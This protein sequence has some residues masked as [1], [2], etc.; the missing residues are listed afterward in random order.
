MPKTNIEIAQQTQ[1]KFHFYITALVFTLLGLSIQTA[2]F[3]NSDVANLL[4]LSGWAAL[5]ISGLTA[6]YRLE[7]IPNL[8]ESAAGLNKLKSQKS[9][10]LQSKKAGQE[11]VF[12]IEENKSEKID[13]YVTDLDKQIARLGDHLM[14][15]QKSIERRYILHKWTFIV[16]LMLVILSRAYFPIISLAGE[17]SKVTV[18]NHEFEVINVLDDSKSLQHFEALWGK[19]T[20]SNTP[21]DTKWIYKIDIAGKGHGDRWLYSPLGYVRVLSKAKV[22]TYAISSPDEFNN[23]L[24]VTNKSLKRG[25]Q[26]TPAP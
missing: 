20:K 8:Y 16:G 24:G 25:G 12:I 13:E 14:S 1:E 17:I 15:V 3:G 9:S 22:P 18:L 6:L 26:K 21:N 7:L 5:L 11:E 19:K 23:L 2:S 10:V 4:E